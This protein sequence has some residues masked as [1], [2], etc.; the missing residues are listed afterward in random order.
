MTTE[1]TNLRLDSRAKTEAYA[2]FERLG[3]KPAQA[4]NMF[5]NQVSLHQGLP[6]EVKIPNKET[7]EAIEELARG[8][9]KTFTSSEEFLKDL[10]GDDEDED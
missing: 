4:I 9:G 8:G 6:F 2:V 7:R 5:L 3:L 10:F 1:P